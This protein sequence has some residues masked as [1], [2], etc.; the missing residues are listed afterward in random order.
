[1]DLVEFHFDRSLITHDQIEAVTQN[2]RDEISLMN[3]ATT[4]GYKD[5]R[6]S[7]NLA[8]DKNT[9]QTVLSLVE[10]KNKLNFRYII[11]VG[12]G[13]SNLG[14]L[15][16]FEAVLGKKFNLK[17]NGKKIVFA[18]TVDSDLLSDIREIIE[19]LLQKNENVLINVVSKSGSTTETI[20]NFEVLLEL[21]G[22]YKDNPCESIVVTTDFNSKLWQ[23]A[24]EKEYSLLEIPKKVGGRYSVFSA[25]GLF[26]LAMI[27]I[28]IQKLLDGAKQMRSRCLDNDL[29]NNPAALAA[30]CSFLHFKDDNN[31]HDLFL[32]SDDLESIGK[33]NRQLIAESVGKE[34]DVSGNQ[35]FTGITPT[36][37]IGSTDLHSVAQLYLGGPFDKFTTF[38]KVKKNK[39]QI[40]VP[41]YS[42]Y[43]SLVKGIQ[44]KEIQDIMNAIYEGVKKAFCKSNRAFM[45]IVLP[46]KTES[47]IGQFLQ[48]KMMETMF[49]GALMNINP[50]DQPNVEMYKIETKKLLQE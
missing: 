10:E 28:N 11:V 49:L 44:N 50:F 18:D 20:A 42:E 4:L 26:P 30:A 34:H 47:T 5:D 17:Q 38:V 35:V 3:Q 9:L 27:G 39:Q 2:I 22:K 13:G 31:I 48:Y 12:I 41:N 32:F 25:V 36:Y 37:S 7:L 40:K 45:E 33:W 16:V 6:A 14:T 29:K 15:A 24:K 21:I 19:P 23:L 1:M 8:F 43:N 46:D